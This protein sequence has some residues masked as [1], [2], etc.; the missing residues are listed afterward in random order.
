MQRQESKI[1]DLGAL[2]DLDFLFFSQTQE[3]YF[4]KNI[5]LTSEII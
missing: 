2:W 5:V 3:P 1:E 4:F